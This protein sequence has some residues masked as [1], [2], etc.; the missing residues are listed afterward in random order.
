[1][2]MTDRE[3]LK[4]KRRGQMKIKRIFDIFVSVIILT[5]LFPLW[6]M[7]AVAIKLTSEGPIFFIQERPGYHR[8]MIRVYKFRTMYTGS[9]KM[10][11][12]QEVKRGDKRI[13]SV[14]HFLRR[15]KIDE[16]PQ[17]INVLKG[18]MSLVGPRPERLESL[19]DYD[20]EISKRLTMLPGMTGLAQV[21]GNIYLSLSDRYKLDVYYVQHFSLLLDTKILCRTVGVVM[22]GEERF[23]GKPLVRVG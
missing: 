3:T 12:G 13:T 16:I 22:L 20:K 1:M 9:E 4:Q 2:K 11:K 8:T 14:G 18:E 7:V 10:V 23:M 6:A 5:G 15:S 19:Q 21:S 17:L